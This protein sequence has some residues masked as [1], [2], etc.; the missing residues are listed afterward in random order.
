MKSQQMPCISQQLRGRGF[1]SPPQYGYFCRTERPRSLVG[2]VPERIISMRRGEISL[3]RLWLLGLR[4]L[5]LRPL[6]LIMSRKFNF[7]HSI[8]RFSAVQKVFLLVSEYASAS[9]WLYLTIYFQL[10][11]G[12]QVTAYR[13]GARVGMRLAGH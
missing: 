7:L 1:S 5:S 6:A 2:I 13:R 9:T 3:F 11:K 8:C 12:D 10:W 4:L